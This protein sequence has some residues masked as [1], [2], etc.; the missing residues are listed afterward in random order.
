MGKKISFMFLLMLIAGQGHAAERC[1]KE[2]CVPEIREIAGTRAELKG[3][4]KFSYWGFDLYKAALYA[5]SGVNTIEGVLGDTP[6]S[7][8]LYYSRKIRNDQ[9]VK[10]GDHNIRKNPDNKMP[11]LEPRLAQINAAYQNVDKGD[12]YELLYE[13]GKGT[14]LL[15]NDVPKVTVPGVD[16]QKAYFGIWL[17]RYPISEDLRDKLLGH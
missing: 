7:L 4:E 10:G 3:L 17:S 5:P 14:T 11:A 9:I 1:L 6:K 15:F 12:R 8:V 2:V 16:F 13:P